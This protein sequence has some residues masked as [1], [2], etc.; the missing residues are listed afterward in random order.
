MNRRT[1]AAALAIATGGLGSAADGAAPPNIICILADDLGYGDVGALNPDGKIRTPNLDRLAAQGMAFTDAHSGSAVCTPT[2]YGL[3]TGRY[4]WR[5]RLASGVLG[6][7]SP[8]LIAP[9][10]ATVASLLKARGYHTACFG[11]W[12]LGMTWAVRDGGDPGDAIDSKVDPRSVDYSAPIRNGP[13]AAG[14]DL[15]YGISASL[16]MPPYVFIENDRPT[17]LP[18]ATKK[19]IRAGPAAPDFEAV[20]VLP[21]LTTRAV[22][23]IRERAR[24]GGPFFL[25]MPLNSPHTP[26]VPTPDC[27]GKSGLGPYGDFTAQTDAAVGEVL[28]ALDE[29]GLAGSTLVLFTSD[30]GCSPSADFPALLAKGHNPSHVFR[31]TKADIFEG[32]HRVPFLVRWPGTV[33]PGSRCDRTVCL[34]DLLATA[35]EISGAA[36]PDGAGEDSFSLVPCL[37]GDDAGHR[38]D[39]TVHH[40]INGSFAIREGRWKLAL[41]S[42]SGGWSAPRP[43]SPQARDLPP[44]QLFDLQADIGETRN[45]SADNPEIV[46]RLTK[47]LQDLVD[48]GRSTPGVAA[49][50]DRTVVI[51]RPASPPAA[52]R[53]AMEK[54]AVEKK[55]KVE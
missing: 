14:F 23:H 41:C 26:I 3:L 51:E 20:D 10:R 45:V 54:K 28:R 49:K 2:R 46:A 37:R 15:Y 8:P 55:A 27:G 1:W 50:N 22:T 19:W 34:T 31:G 24:A 12:H 13:N 4:A 33:R 30:N 17:A 47:R 35:A 53:K 32:G 52:E 39:A 42:D 18:T 36:V 6:G 40:S 44:A 43:N 25:Y 21:A 7:Y 29:T 9:G 16:D 5:T 48:R 11:K 38:R